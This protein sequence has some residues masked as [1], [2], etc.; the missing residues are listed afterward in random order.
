MSKDYSNDFPEI[1]EV[2]LRELDR[3]FPNKVPTDPNISEGKLRILQGQQVVME[4][5]R[6]QFEQ[7]N[8]TILE[9]E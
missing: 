5:L 9:N 4:F 1:P 3:R 6:H 7:Q 8:K 2:L